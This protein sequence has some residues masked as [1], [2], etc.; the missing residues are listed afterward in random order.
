VLATG[1]AGGGGRAGKKYAAHDRRV[2]VLSLT[3]STYMMILRVQIDIFTCFLWF[4]ENYRRN[5]DRSFI[6]FAAGW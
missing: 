6:D 1:G 3:P 2:M 4:S 5:T